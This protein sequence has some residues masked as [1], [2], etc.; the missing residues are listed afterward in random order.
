MVVRD[1]F[2]FGNIQ[3]GQDRSQSNHAGTAHFAA[4]AR[5]RV[6]CIAGIENHSAPSLHVA[7]DFFQCGLRRLWG[8][9]RDRPI[10]QRKKGEFVAGGIQPNRLERFQGRALRQEQRETLQPG[11]A[12]VVDGRIAGD[13]IGK[14]GLQR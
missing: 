5:R 3:R 12:D 13:D 14:M 2:E 10:D 7:V 6:H 1:R 8:A 11:L 4:G 9:W